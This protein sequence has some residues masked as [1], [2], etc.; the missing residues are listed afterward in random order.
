MFKAYFYLSMELVRDV[1]RG[2]EEVQNHT[3]LCCLYALDWWI[4]H[5]AAKLYLSGVSNWAIQMLTRLSQHQNGD[6]HAQ[7]SLFRNFSLLFI[8][9]LMQNYFRGL[10]SFMLI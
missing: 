9:L 1:I 10:V 3:I 6:Q 2:L 4:V 7:R 8:F 5:G